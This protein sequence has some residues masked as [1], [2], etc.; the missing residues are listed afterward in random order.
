MRNFGF[1]LLGVTQSVIGRQAY[2]YVQWLG[3][4]TNDQGYEI[5]EW[6]DPVPRQAGIYPMSRETIREMGLE[7]EKQYIQI[8]D[9]E[10]I[11]LLSRGSN[12]DKIIF[13]GGEWRALPTSN[14]W[15]PS[16]GWGQVIAVRLGDA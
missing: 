15:F 10:L 14:D 12:A 7:F 16:G 3:R 9:T 4:T 13:N 6:A 1:N 8:F 5:D 11:G 2:D